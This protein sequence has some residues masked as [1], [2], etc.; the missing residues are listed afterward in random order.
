M[1]SLK[2]PKDFPVIEFRRYTIKDGQRQRFARYFEDYFPE[3]IQ[4]S[5]AIVA[6]AFLERERSDVFTWIR[7]F[8]DMDDR[9]KLSA[10]LYYGAVWK[11]HRT[12]MNSL[13]VDSDNALLLRPVSPECG[14]IVLPAVDRFEESEGAQGV[15]VAQIFPLQ[16]NTADA[17]VQKTEPV[18]AEYRSIGLREAG[19]LVTLDAP[20]NFPQLPVRADGHYLIWLGLCRD[21]EALEARF[22]PV[23]T[24]NLQPL[25]ASGLLRGAAELVVM[26]PTARSR[27]RWWP[28]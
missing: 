2:H 8:R 11:E 9:A 26:D 24:R 16:P 23:A 18:F 28:A 5:G 13:M 27:L 4:Q 17:F 10:A 22:R 25:A 7:A 15:A 6:G 12:L 3:A 19:V 1:E 21:N 14:V 20:N